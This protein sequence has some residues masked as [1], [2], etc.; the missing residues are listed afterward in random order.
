[1][2]HILLWNIA[3]VWSQNLYG[4]S[5]CG[6]S[7]CQKVKQRH[8]KDTFFELTVTGQILRVIQETNVASLF[9]EEASEVVFIYCHRITNQYTHVAETGHPFSIFFFLKAQ[10]SVRQPDYILCSFS[11][12]TEIKL[13]AKL[14]SSLEALG[15]NLLPR[16][17]LCTALIFLVF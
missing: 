5:G 11:Y 17:Q 7:K 14:C 9:I 1:M 8:L 2:I 10:D 12:Q 13:S 15:M 6:F 4:K 16:L 3:K